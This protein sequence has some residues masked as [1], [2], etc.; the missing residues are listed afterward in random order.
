MQASFPYQMR[1]AKS[2]WMT[3]LIYSL[4]FLSALPFLF[5][6][7]Y[8]IE[9]GGAALG[10]DL[11]TKLPESAG[12]SRGGLA[13]GIY[14]SVVMT[15]LAG[16]AGA[17]CG[18]LL[19][20]SL[21]EYRH[22]PISKVLRFVIDLFISAPSI[23]IGIFVY[24]LIVSYFGFS[25]Y[26]GAFALWMIF[27]PLTARTT[28]EILA[29][30]PHHI[31]EAG[32]ALGLP[33][34]KMILR[35]LVPGALGLLLTGMILSLARIAGETAPLLFTA[36][37]N[38]FFS[39][40]LSEPIASLPVQIYKFAGSG[41]ASLE[42]L[43]WAGALI[44]MAFVFLVNLSVRSAAFFLTRRTHRIIKNPQAQ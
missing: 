28:E 13:N 15:A 38:N 18:V 44:L 43:A 33:R 11:F 1:K 36:L 3:G 22:S 30:V 12:Q 17:P 8:V 39:K 35:I 26:A 41:F 5:I 32:L 40:S 10:W 42:T 7:Y 23:I 34:W 25:A 6:V 19:G 27:T 21:Y 9:K 4:S 29:M 31:R 2:H 37:G 14:G 16:I 24:S 20:I